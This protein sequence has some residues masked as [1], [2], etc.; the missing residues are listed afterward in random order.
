MSPTQ[1]ERGARFKRLHRSEGIFLM[2]NAWNAGSA[3]LLKR[4]RRAVREM[5][6]HGTFGY[7]GDQVPDA[8]LCRLFS[9]RLTRD[10]S[11]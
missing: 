9:A 1:A 4:I 3:Y 11:A 2:P 7:A 10:E 6:D 5:Q 8:E